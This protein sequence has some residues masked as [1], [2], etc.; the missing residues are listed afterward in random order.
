MKIGTDLN[1]NRSSLS[2]S[3]GSLRGL[4][5]D[6]L[7]LLGGFGSLGS[8]GSCSSTIEGCLLGGSLETTVTKL[9]RGVDELK[10][11]LLEGG[12]GGVG[13]QGLPEHED[14]LLGTDAAA[15]DD[16]EVVSD[17][18]VVGESAER[19]D[20]LV[21]GV[22]GSGG[23]VLGTGALA[24]SDSVD[25]LVGFGSV[26]VAEL[27]GSGDAP[28]DSGW[29]PGSNTADLPVTSVGLLL[30]M[31]DSKSLHDT[32][33]SL[34][35]GDTDDVE[36]LVLG[37]DL[38]DS[39]LL[40][41]ES[42]AI[43]DLLG[44]VLAAVDLD[45][46]DVVLLLSEVLE[47]LQLGVGDDPHDRAVLLDSVELGLELLGGLGDL[48]VVL[49]EGFLLGVHPVLVESPEGVL[50]EVA[51]PDGRQGPQASGGVNIPDQSD[52]ADGWG[53]DDGHGLHDLLLVELGSWSVHLSH[54]VG[55]PCL[56]TSERCEVAWLLVVVLGE[57]ADA[58]PVVSGSAPGHKS[59]IS[60]SWA[61]VFSVAHL[62]FNY[63]LI[64]LVNPYLYPPITLDKISSLDFGILSNQ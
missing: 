61:T 9:G 19:G 49:A 20:V 8:L 29:M 4:F 16:E 22:S 23:V 12:L 44:D 1:R 28:G 56:E 26:V 33:V 58:A 41:E 14:S 37:E 25:L 40:L 64:F 2:G 62:I 27:T 13:D 55:H 48:V 63:L 46:E 18:T 51:G 32:G 34:S 52:N 42:I 54:D 45:L 11:D 7:V 31:P 30:E 47:Q 36:V 15:L 21:G 59:E 50:L 39:D 10:G 17:D 5:L 57:R 24:L 53:L 60:L 38:V 3:R 43:V 35:L 6:W